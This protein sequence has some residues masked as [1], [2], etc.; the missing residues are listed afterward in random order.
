MLVGRD[1]ELSTFDRVIAAGK[2]ALIIVTSDPNMGKSSLLGAF[3]QRAKQ[4]DYIVF[5]EATTPEGFSTSISID[6]KITKEEFRQAISLPLTAGAITNTDLY[7]VNSKSALIL[8]DGYRPQQ[9]F[10]D[11]F[12]NEF[13]LQSAAATPPR[14]VV[15][16]AAASDVERLKPYATKEM[17]LK[18]I[19]RR[20]IVTYLHTLNDT[21]QDKMQE[22]EIR[23]YA[24]AL[25]QK[26]SLIEALGRLLKIDSSASA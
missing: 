25:C 18:P 4:R 17:L 6:R 7:E 8:I 19:A 3:G 10:E 9:E 16:A 15:V 20:A 11:W 12:I 26:P 22:K 23:V 2:S 14:I 13:I 1:K 21:L 5:P 24:G